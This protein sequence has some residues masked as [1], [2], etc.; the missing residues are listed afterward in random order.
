M[1]VGDLVRN[2]NSESGLLGIIV[3]WQL[4]SYGLSDPVVFWKDG[5]KS[6]IRVDRVEVVCEGR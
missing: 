3:G 1:R 4:N 2:L 5:R 6:W